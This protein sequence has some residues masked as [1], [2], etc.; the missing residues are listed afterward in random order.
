MIVCLLLGAAALIQALGGDT[1]KQVDRE[2]APAATSNEPSDTQS[3]VTFTSVPP[4]TA[5]S[6]TI[7]R[8]ASSTTTSTPIQKP[9]SVTQISEGAIKITGYGS[10]IVDVSGKWTNYRTVIYRSPVPGSQLLIE[11]RGNGQTPLFSFGYPYQN[12]PLE[13]LRFLSEDTQAVQE[14]A[15]TASANWEIELLPDA[16]LWNQQID[17]GNVPQAG[18]FMIFSANGMSFV[19]SEKNPIARGAGDLRVYNA[20]HSPCSEETTTWIFELGPGCSDAP[21]LS[22]REV[23]SDLFQRTIRPTKSEAGK[24]FVEV[25]LQNYDWLEVLTPCQW[26][27]KPT[28]K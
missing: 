15:V 13:G 14:I 2:T 9:I 18:E 21:R 5:P 24:D 3:D 7:K 10:S 25:S 28:S 20:C 26:S 16:F 22:I 19:G 17:A 27:A 12:S 1:S 11:L 4:T 23:G 6:T 8:T